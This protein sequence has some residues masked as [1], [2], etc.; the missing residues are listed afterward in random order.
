MLFPLLPSRLFPT[1]CAAA[2]LQREVPICHTISNENCSSQR[3]PT[4]APLHQSA[5]RSANA[6]VG[7]SSVATKSTPAALLS[8][9]WATDLCTASP[10]MPDHLCCNE[11]AMPLRTLT[12]NPLVRSQASLGTRSTHCRLHLP[13]TSLRKQSSSP[14][15]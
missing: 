7:S 15:Y 10:R 6:G 8:T 12:C 14:R 5:V 4:A 9:T 13:Y 11:D 1:W 2:S 3:L